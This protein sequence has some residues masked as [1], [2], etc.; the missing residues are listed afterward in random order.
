MSIRKLKMKAALLAGVVFAGLSLANTTHADSGPST[1]TDN[2]VQ[3]NE[4]ISPEGFKHPGIRFTKE[5]LENLRTQVIAGQ[6]PWASYYEG[7]RR[8]HWA[9]LDY[10]PRN[11]DGNGY[12]AHDVISHNGLIA[13]FIDDAQAALMHSVQYVVTG[14]ERH[15]EKAMYIVGVYSHMNP[16]GVEYFADAHI[17]MGQPIYHMTAAAEILRA[18]STTR[19]EL[20]W[21]EEMTY[22]YVHN[23][24][25]PQADAYIRKNHYFMN[26]YS[27]ALIGNVASAIFADD[28]AAYEEAVEWATVGSTAENQGWVGSIERQFRLVTQNDQT[29]EPLEEP[30]IQ[31]VEM[32]RDQAHAIGNVDSLF[33]ISQIIASQDTKV[34][35]VTGTVSTASDAIDPVHFSDDALRKAYIQFAKYNMGFDIPWVPVAS[36]ILADGSIDSLYRW[37]RSAYRGRL[38]ANAF[39]AMYY[40]YEY[41]ADGYDLTEGDNRFIQMIYEKSMEHSWRGVRSGG[42]WGPREHVYDSEFWMHLPASV[43][44]T[45]VP[46][47]GEPRE[48]LDELPPSGPAHI[49]EVE[50]KEI[51]LGGS[52]QEKTEGEV[53][54][55]SV[56]TTTAEPAVFVLWSAWF[57]DS[58]NAFKVRSDGPATIEFARG[59]DLPATTQLHVP[60][61]GGEWRYIP[62]DT[63][64]RSTWGSGDLR[65][66]RV[67]GGSITTVV[68]IDHVNT[69]DDTLTPPVFDTLSTDIL[70]YAG[71]ELDRSFAAAAEAGSSPFYFTEGMVPASATLDSSTGR[72][73]WAPASGDAGEYRFHVVAEDGEYMTSHQVTIMVTAS[74]EAAVELV[75]EAMEPGVAYES[76]GREAF[77]AAHTA[78]LDAIHAGGSLAEIDM[79]I[80]R[81]LVAARA[82]QPLNPVIPEEGTKDELGP[83]ANGVRLDY[84]SIVDSANTRLNMLVDGDSSSANSRWGDE[85]YVLLDFGASFRVVTEAVHIHPRQAFPDRTRGTHVLASDD[86]VN[87]LKITGNVGYGDRMH[88]LPVYEEFRNRAF[89]YLKFYTDPG[90]CG[91]PVLDFGEIYIFGER[92]EVIA[93]L[94]SAP[95]RWFVGET[96]EIPVAVTPTQDDPVEFSADLPA[97]AVFDQ[98]RGLITWTPDAGQVGDQV[99]TIRA[100]FGYAQVED[101]LPIT[102]SASADAAIDELLE[103]LGE[104]ESY[105]EASLTMLARAEA[106]TRLITSN[107]DEP[108]EDR[109]EAIAH[110][111]RVMELVEPV[112]TGDD[113]DA[114]RFAGILASHSQRGAPEIDETLAGVPAFDRDPS[115]YVNLE[116]PSGGWIQADFG[117][118]RYVSLTQVRLTPRYDFGRKLNNAV[119]EGSNDGENW[120]RLAKVPYNEYLN[121]TWDN[122][123]TTLEVSDA[124][125]YRYVRFVGHNGSYGNVAEVELFGS[126]DYALDDRTLRYLQLKASTLDAALWDNA[127][128][129]QLQDALAQ[130]EKASGIY[131]V[132]AA[133]A[134][135]EKALNMLVPASGNLSFDGVPERWFVDETLEF[136]IFPEG[137]ADEGVYVTAELPDGATFDP[138]TG[139]V[140]WALNSDQLGRQELRFAVSFDYT[141]VRLQV[142][143]PVTVFAD[144]SAAVDEILTTTGSLDQ[145]TQFS[146]DMLERAESEVREIAADPAVGPY[147]KLSYLDLLEQAIALLEPFSDTINVAG[148][149]SILASHQ[150]WGTPEEGVTLSGLPAFDG[151]RSTYVDLQ[152]PS[153]TWVQADF[154]EGRYVSLTRVRLTPRWDYGRRLNNSVIE[155]SN[156]GE[157][158]TRL[159]RVPHDEYLQA[160]WDNHVTTLEV[161]DDTPYRYVRLLGSNGSHGNIAEIELFGTHNLDHDDRTLPYLIAKAGI[162]VENDWTADSW[163]Y[164]MDVLAVAQAMIEEGGSDEALY[165]DAT[166]M[167]DEA[168]NTLVPASSYLDFIVANV[169]ASEADGSITLLVSR[170][171]GTLGAVSADFATLAGSASAGEDFVDTNGT[172]TWV[173]GDMNPKAI[174][175]SLV[176]DGYLEDEEDFT[177]KLENADNGV[178]GDSGEA[179]VTLIDDDSDALP[180]LSIADASLVE[181]DGKL[182]FAAPMQFEVPLPGTARQPAMPGLS[183]FGGF[184]LVEGDGKLPFAASKQCEVPLSGT[185]RQPAMPGLSFGGFSLVEGDGKLPS[186]ASMQFKVSLSGTARQPVKVLVRTQSGTAKNGR[187]FIPLGRVVHF[188]V[189]EKSKVVEVRV[190]PDH[191]RE[192]DEQ[193]TLEAIWAK[194]AEVQDGVGVGTILDDD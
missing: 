76:S 72:F 93:D 23:F 4:T 131:A 25:Q 165:A 31:L 153:G 175:V 12:P 8:R 7:M 186:A 77:H 58:V 60:D 63:S 64:K 180:G 129:Q 154:G 178:I 139:L 140:S 85:P 54:Y 71:G 83:E 145:Y 185:A 66:I 122:H 5:S 111:E 50:K 20:E 21:T 16:N 74:A 116:V 97:G 136:S 155:G 62:F 15:R 34:D 168:L 120:T 52:V 105:T 130:A 84:P 147:R 70:T 143:L 118:G 49:I 57:S 177:V 192:G 75:A 94:A 128:W 164:L 124:T 146:V 158:W 167:L 10:G 142:S 184:S 188:A 87:W 26:Q 42:Y 68:D 101:S 1:I 191:K 148:E 134:A 38:R 78:A 106:D 157:N 18:T 86:G 40:F 179:E 43:A 24:L 114:G 99:L 28:R 91:C 14:D 123:V 109:L 182:P 69:S 183:F 174:V 44:D 162:L 35:P 115:T 47:R 127:S 121:A 53:S 110:F 117:E 172:L 6:E 81:F 170:T 189:G 187:D 112:H 119:I 82:L 37:P 173:D 73:N 137:V 107:P 138:V 194:G 149:A 13:G 144:A 17:K 126:G 90:V 166:A 152:S 176:N 161:S 113:I 181:G 156:D 102:V 133:T 169:Q 163:Q 39:P 2:V 159:A 103:S 56:D 59:R 95:P 36:S 125:A 80:A 30:H 88:R 45:S 79:A 29:G 55:L 96:L 193:F 98:A 41:M 51:V 22:N 141:P 32:G 19:P 11:H 160:T 33:I 65:Y 190:R 92:K 108:I 104:P 100:D 67:I 132:T 48:V 61:T 150:R 135:L 171:G 27:Y 3:I 9:R 46:P 89:R 151:E